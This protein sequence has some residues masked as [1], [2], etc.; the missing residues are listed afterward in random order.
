MQIKHCFLVASLLATPFVSAADAG[1]GIEFGTKFQ[2]FTDSNF[3]G[4]SANY[5]RLVFAESKNSSFYFQ[6]ESGQINAS[7]GDATSVLST[8]VTGIGASTMVAPSIYADIMVGSSSINGVAA[9]GTGTNA[10]TA[11]QSTSPIAEVGVNWVKNTGSLS[12]KAGASYRILTSS[13]TINFTDS[14]GKLN[15]ASD[16]SSV[17]LNLA[18]NYSF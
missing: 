10:I 11:I 16:L 8:S 17:H 7:V 4:G 6:N 12:L 18:L 3:D 15:R 2:T 9:T 5:F 14:S 13:N 1:L